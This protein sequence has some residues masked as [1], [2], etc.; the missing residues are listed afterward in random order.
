MKGE[1]GDQGAD[2]DVRYRD[3]QGNKG[4]RGVDGSRGSPADPIP[5]VERGKFLYH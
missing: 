2:G 3:P 5:S 4:E 1:K